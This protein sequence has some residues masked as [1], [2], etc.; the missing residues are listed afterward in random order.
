MA[1]DYHFISEEEQ[2]LLLRQHATQIERELVRLEIELEGSG[3]VTPDG[4]EITHQRI[5][6]MTDQIAVIDKRLARLRPAKKADE[7]T[8][9]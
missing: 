1:Y 8:D 2:E 3:S 7:E 4:T 5:K 9:G 6:R